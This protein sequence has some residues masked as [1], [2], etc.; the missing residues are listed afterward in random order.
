MA[1][2]TGNAGM[3]PEQRTAEHMHRCSLMREDQDTA[4]LPV[5]TGSN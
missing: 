2:L 4:N 5:R 3:Q 1:L